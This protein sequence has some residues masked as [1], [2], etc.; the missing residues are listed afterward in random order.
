MKTFPELWANYVQKK[1]KLKDP[2]ALVQMTSA[3]FR[4]ALELAWEQALA[5]GRHEGFAEAS[6]R[7][8][9]NPFPGAFERMFGGGK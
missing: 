5:E 2:A 1:P 3:Q 7:D 6:K 8:E 9:P 4:Q